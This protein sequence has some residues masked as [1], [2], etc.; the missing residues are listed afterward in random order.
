[1]PLPAITPIDF[2]ELN[3]IISVTTT[4]AQPRNLYKITVPAAGD[5]T[6]KASAI[7]VDTDIHFYDEAGA[8]IVYRDSV[9][10]GGLETITHAVAGAGIFYA[11]VGNWS[12]TACTF[13]FEVSFVA[14]VVATP[15]PVTP[16][17]VEP[18]PVTPTPTPTT[19]PVV[20]P[21][22]AADKLAI[23]DLKL[24]IKAGEA[25][26]DNEIVFYKLGDSV[27]AEKVVAALDNGK[28]FNELKLLGLSDAMTLDILSIY[29]VRIDPLKYE[30]EVGLDAIAANQPLIADF[31]TYLQAQTP[32]I[33]YPP[34][35][36]LFTVIRANPPMYAA[37]RTW[38][39]T[40]VK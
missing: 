17:P 31:F 37:L 18:P 2:G 15:P 29:N 32:P 3:R 1:M 27:L 6:I 23:A 4:A 35:T 19:P 26:T 33:P 11:N 5:L 39:A 25:L 7:D 30:S 21:Q 40:R 24:R 28:G 16:P 22:V 34:L 14:T 9:K 10:V 13:A 20:D 36:S 38:N 8:E 12:D